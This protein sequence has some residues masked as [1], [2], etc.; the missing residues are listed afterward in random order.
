MVEANEYSLDS[1]QQT[2]RKLRNSKMA[3][4]GFKIFDLKPRSNL[5]PQKARH[6]FGRIIR[7]MIFL[8]NCSLN[9]LSAAKVWNSKS[10]K[11]KSGV[12]K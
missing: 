6:S 1:A 7:K 9:I 2:R 5:P 3:Q 8:K 4:L 10:L 12:Q 11:T